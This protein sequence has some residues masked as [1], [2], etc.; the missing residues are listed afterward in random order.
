MLDLVMKFLKPLIAGKKRIFTRNVEEVIVEQLQPPYAKNKVCSY[1][2]KVQVMAGRL[3]GAF[4]HLDAPRLRL[5]GGVA[6]GGTETADG[7]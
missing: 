7:W 6:V 3:R 2:A 1:P 4:E 5:G